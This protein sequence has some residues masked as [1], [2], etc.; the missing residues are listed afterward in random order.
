M[1]VIFQF[2]IWIPERPNVKPCEKE[3]YFA[4][5]AFLFKA[6]IRSYIQDR[7]KYDPFHWL[8]R[9]SRPDLKQSYPAQKLAAL[10]HYSDIAIL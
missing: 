9:I 6:G 4:C 10:L 2:E 3:I 5:K 1:L 8:D 7:L